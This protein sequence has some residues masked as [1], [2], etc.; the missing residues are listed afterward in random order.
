M[1][2]SG[3]GGSGGTTAS[4]GTAGSGGTTASGGTAGS[5]GT[6]TS[7]TTTT[8]GP[9]GCP[10]SEPTPNDACS[11]AALHCTYGDSPSP[12]CRKGFLCQDGTWLADGLGCDPG[13]AECPAGATEGAECTEQPNSCVT[14]VQVC[15]CGPCG[16]AG[17]PDPPWSWVCGAIPG[18]GCPD[19]L[20]N[21]GTACDD[22]TLV[23]SYGVFCA[24]EAT[25]R[26]KNGAWKWDPSFA[27]P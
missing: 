3:G 24:D 12:S 23:C 27:C 15:V 18:M 10:P 8:T 20:P 26:C 11:V 21:D 9:T 17:C 19:A 16:G 14:A 6:T 4:G 7:T 5:G 13:P 2:G 22:P 1:S 25:A